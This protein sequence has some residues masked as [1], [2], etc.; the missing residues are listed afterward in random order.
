MVRLPPPS[1]LAISTFSAPALVQLPHTV[2][3]VLLPI[4]QPPVSTL[5]PYTTLFRSVMLVNPK[6]PS[7]WLNPVPVKAKV[8]FWLDEPIIAKLA[9]LRSEE[10]TSEL[11]S[12]P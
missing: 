3:V 8:A 6:L 10:Q 1:E 9:P 5:F 11:Q 12:R 7:F 4:P 2:T